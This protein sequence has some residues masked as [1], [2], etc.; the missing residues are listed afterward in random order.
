MESQAERCL[1]CRERLTAKAWEYEGQPFC[2]KGCAHEFSVASIN[3]G[4][5]VLKGNPLPSRT[6][7]DGWNQLKLGLY[8]RLAY[9]CGQ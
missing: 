9:P 6:R 2:S 5:S 4:F 1:W 7:L 8:G 3:K